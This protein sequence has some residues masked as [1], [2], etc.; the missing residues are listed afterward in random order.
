[1]V[2]IAIEKKTIRK[3]GLI[4][5]HFK[6]NNAGSMS[7]II[8]EL[9]N[10]ALELNRII[11]NITIPLNNWSLKDLFRQ[12][13]ALEKTITKKE[14]IMLFVFKETINNRKIFL[15]SIIKR[16]SWVKPCTL[17]EAL[18]IIKKLETQGLILTIRKCQKCGINFNVIPYKCDNCGHIFILNKNSSKNKRSRPRFIIEITKLGISFVNHFIETQFY[19]N[20]FLQV[21]QSY[22]YTK[23][24][25]EI[26]K[27]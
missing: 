20:S 18:N 10:I 22:K 12:L 24:S 2:R 21:L 26:V 8:E 25:E 17:Q 14:R 13:Y 11:Q 19:V 5:V 15:K 1:M 16:L 27:K 7:D 9:C 6:I 23:N 3:L 4:R